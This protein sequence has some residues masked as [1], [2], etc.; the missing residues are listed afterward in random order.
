MKGDA[1]RQMAARVA[2]AEKILGRPLPKE[3]TKASSQSA[4]A[5]SG[6]AKLVQ[7][8]VDGYEAGERGEALEILARRHIASQGGKARALK[9][10]PA[11]LSELGRKGWAAEEG[12]MK[13]TASVCRCGGCGT[14]G[15]GDMQAMLA[16]VA[17]RVEAERVREELK[18]RERAEARAV[19]MRTPLEPS[20][21]T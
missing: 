15:R 14:V 9:L 10:S 12:R 20:D 8:I 1:D 3:A 19:R 5:G 2:Q 11:R 17:V 6:L 4:K 18:A 16:R 7:A 13:C 21:G